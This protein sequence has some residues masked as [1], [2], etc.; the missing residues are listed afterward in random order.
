M[1]NSA[2]DVSAFPEVARS[3]L[4][5]WPVPGT[6]TG[7]GARF[8]AVAVVIAGILSF[9]AFGKSGARRGQVRQDYDRVPPVL[10][11]E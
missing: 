11:I 6:S 8:G 1:I 7:T 3:V 9:P 4:G 5:L 2:T 10:G